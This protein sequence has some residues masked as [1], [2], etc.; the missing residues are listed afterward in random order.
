[1]EIAESLVTNSR[2]LVANSI[3]LC[4]LTS[5]RLKWKFQGEDETSTR[6]LLNFQTLIFK[7]AFKSVLPS[8]T[9]GLKCSFLKLMRGYKLFLS[10]PKVPH[11][12]P[13]TFG[14][15][16]PSDVMSGF[17]KSICG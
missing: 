3:F 11:K 8:K 10:L 13:G 2:A 16:S 15:P 6:L 12:H 9:P 1:M 7:K 17:E 5:K 4:A 14:I